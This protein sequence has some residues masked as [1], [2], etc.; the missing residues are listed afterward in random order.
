MRRISHQQ[1]DFHLLA[2]THRSRTLMVDNVKS[3]Y[4]KVCPDTVLPVTHEARR[5]PFT[6]IL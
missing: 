6:N 2:S 1:H 4:A 3:A 5:K